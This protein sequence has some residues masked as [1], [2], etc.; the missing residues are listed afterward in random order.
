MRSPLQNWTWCSGPPSTSSTDYFTQMLFFL[1]PLLRCETLFFL[2]PLWS[3]DTLLMF[4]NQYSL[5]TPCKCINQSCFSV[6]TQIDRTHCFTSVCWRSHL[7]YRTVII[8]FFIS[9]SAFFHQQYFYR[10][11]NPWKFLNQSRPLAS[12]FRQPSSLAY[13]EAK[14][15]GKILNVILEKLTILKIYAKFK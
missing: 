4:A 11:I 1:H 15:N 3:S 10:D 14:M 7:W 9:T 6:S 2:N 8:I 13:T 5:S 12:E